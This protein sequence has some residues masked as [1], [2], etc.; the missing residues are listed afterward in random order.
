MSKTGQKAKS[1]LNL[2][3]NETRR[4]SSIANISFAG[5]DM[6]V[7]KSKTKFKED[8]DP[9][10]NKMQMESIEATLIKPPAMRT[11]MQTQRVALRLEGIKYFQSIIR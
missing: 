10:I 1:H 3:I 5:L 11:F 6:Q 2:V 7:K 4:K 8:E 9:S